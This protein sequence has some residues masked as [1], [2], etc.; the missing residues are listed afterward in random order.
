MSEELARCINA[1]PGGP[2]DFWSRFSSSSPW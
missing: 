1:Q 2:G